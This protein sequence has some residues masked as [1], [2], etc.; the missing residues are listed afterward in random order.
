MTDG[1][2]TVKVTDMHGCTE[3]NSVTLTCPPEVLHPGEESSDGPQAPPGCCPNLMDVNL[4]P[5]PNTGAFTVTGLQ[6]GMV[7]DIYD[8][9]GRKVLTAS[10][11][12]VTMQ[13]NISDQPNG[14]YLVRIM[15]KDGTMVAQKKVV[16]TQ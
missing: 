15:D 2:Y 5:N 4:Y 8:I 12:G 14:I 11:N 9:T 10:T 3:T 13:F 6:A 1:T 16:K 7:V